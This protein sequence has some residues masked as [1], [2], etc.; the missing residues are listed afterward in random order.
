MKEKIYRNC[1]LSLVVINIWTIYIFFYF[2]F[3]EDGFMRGFSTALVYINSCWIASGLG[4]FSIL[5][6]FTILRKQKLY[7]L[8]FQFLYVLIGIF[9]IYFSLI[10]ILLLSLCLIELG[11]FFTLFLVFNFLFSI[12]ISFD[13]IKNLKI[14]S[15]NFK[16][17]T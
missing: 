13:I 11:T 7:D 6:R 15:L 4:F 5:Y 14:Q 3:N 16:I 9:N 17:E 2:F 8:K 10:F 1:S 12:F